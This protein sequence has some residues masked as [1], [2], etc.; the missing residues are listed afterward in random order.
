MLPNTLWRPWEPRAV[1]PVFADAQNTVDFMVQDD[2]NHSLRSLA[3]PFYS[4]LKKRKSVSGA[5]RDYRN[6]I[7]R[8]PYRFRGALISRAGEFIKQWDL[9]RRLR[10]GDYFSVNIN[11]LC[12]DA[13]VRLVDGQLVLIANRGRADVWSSSPGSATMRYVGESYVAGFRTG[14][15]TRV[16]NPVSGKKHVGFTGINPQVLVGSDIVASVLLLN[17]SSDPGH[18]RAVTPTIRLYRN[19]C[20]F[21][22]CSFG[23]IPPHGALERTVLDL[24]SEARDF[25]K[26]TGGRGFTI[27]RAAGVSLASIHLLRSLSNT[28]LGMDH[29]RPAFTN[30]VDY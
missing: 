19:Q 29:S 30:V 28:T 12:S 14:L 13:G 5:F 20:D 22:E 7:L 24:F 2:G 8:R 4:V 3:M 27:V 23:E 1:F 21:L 25:L 17:H 16:L 6:L 26:S 10:T 11:R 18:D 9:G 15:F